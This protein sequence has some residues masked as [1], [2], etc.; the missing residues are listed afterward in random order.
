MAVL[1]VVST[2][3]LSGC[4]TI[5]KSIR[6]SEVAV[7]PATY[8]QIALSPVLYQGQ[9]VRVGGKVINV[10]NLPSKTI[11]EIAV[12]PLNEYARPKINETFQGRVLVYTDNFLDPDNFRNRFVTVLG[13]IEGTENQLIGKRPYRFLKMSV[14]GYQVWQVENSIIPNDGWVYAWSPAW[15]VAPPPGYFYASPEAVSQNSYLE[16]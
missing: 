7:N 2:L 15:G 4:S 13:K 11:L 16:P 12:L 6:G 1:A 9:E 5:P 10:I 14:V 3:L 8:E